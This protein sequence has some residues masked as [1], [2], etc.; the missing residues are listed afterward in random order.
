MFLSI[1]AFDTHL[2]HPNV[3]ILTLRNASAE[4]AADGIKSFRRRLDEDG[5]R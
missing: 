5:V 3:I 4:Q 2:N 1:S